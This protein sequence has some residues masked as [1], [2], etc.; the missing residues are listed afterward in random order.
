MRRQRK[1]KGP[2]ET[3]LF[4]DKNVSV[5]TSLVI[6]WFIEKK[7]KKAQ[8]QSLLEND[9]KGLHE[10][11]VSIF[12]NYLNNHISLESIYCNLTSTVHMHPS[13]CTNISLDI[14]DSEQETHLES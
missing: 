4:K 14:Y 13:A 11:C 5:F 3:A 12:I 2:C 8:K 9:L 6:S 7:G 10:R 1:K